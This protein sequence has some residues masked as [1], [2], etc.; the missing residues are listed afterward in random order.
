MRDNVPRLIYWPSFELF[1]WVGGYVP[2]MYGQEDNSTIH[3]SES[4]VAVV[5][6]TFVD[7]LS[8]GELAKTAR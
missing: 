8:G 5:V 6:D 2:G 1:R 3:A 4:V 7:V